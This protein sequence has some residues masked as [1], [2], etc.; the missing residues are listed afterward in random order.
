M[1]GIDAP[2]AVR[3]AAWL[4]LAMVPVGLLLALHGL[5][6]LRWWGTGEASRLL[7][8]LGQLQEEYGLIPPA[9]LRGRD[10]AVQLVVLGAAGMAYGILGFW[11]LRGRLW[12]RTWALAAGGLTFLVG[13]IGVGSDAAEAH[14][15]G[16]YFAQMRGSAIPERIPAVRELF[17][18]GWYSWA[19][20]ILQGLQVLVTLAAVIALIAAV[21][22]H[23]EYFLPRAS[24]DAEPDEWDA[25]LARMRQQTKPDPE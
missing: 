19:E 2:R 4:T 24:A 5:L 12:A 14:T 18:P 25:A 10:G 11:I 20:D 3:V 16:S 7:A 22:A 15:P 6:E 8:L 1:T 13:L 21:I 23:S 9:L 17:Y